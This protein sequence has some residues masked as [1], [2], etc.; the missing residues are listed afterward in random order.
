MQRLRDAGQKG[1]Q[2]W[3][4]KVCSLSLELIVYAETI[5]TLPICIKVNL[6]QYDVLLVIINQGHCHWTLLVCIIHRCYIC[7]IN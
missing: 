2:K 4:Q 3:H 5:I 1:V 6:L 7:T